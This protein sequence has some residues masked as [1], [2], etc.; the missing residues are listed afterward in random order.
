MMLP[1]QMAVS[2][3]QQLELTRNLLR[4][5]SEA[6]SKQSTILEEKE[7]QIRELQARVDSYRV[8]LDKQNI[9]VQQL[10]DSFVQLQINNYQ[11]VETVKWPPIEP[12]AI[13]SRLRSLRDAIQDFGRTYSAQ[14][15]DE[16]SVDDPQIGRAVVGALSEVVR[17]DRLDPQQCNLKAELREV[18]K[19]AELCLTGLLSHTI[20]RLFFGDPFFFITDE[21]LDSL[22]RIISRQSLQRQNPSVNSQGLLTI[23]SVAQQGMPSA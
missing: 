11:H 14:R 3:A 2:T 16:T 22:R 19:A 1:K 8:D 5:R 6:F 17:F 4:E 15:M 21:L 20:C 7:N 13:E 10:N 18:K 23:Y 9:E 12:S